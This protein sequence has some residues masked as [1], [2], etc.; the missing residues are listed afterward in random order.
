MDEA[1]ASGAEIQGGERRRQRRVSVAG[2]A[3]VEGGGQPPSVWRI[4]N[5]SVGGASL[6]GGTLPSGPLSVSFHVAGFPAVEVAA[7]I[8][9]RQLV[10]RAGRSAVKFMDVPET[11]RQAL[12]EI[13]GADHAP[14]LVS[15]RALIV[16]REI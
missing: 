1:R 11:H 16:H 9:R 8:L 2:I 12:R 10:T 6:V 5:L 4:A 13:L 7:K 3:V 15:R 14:L